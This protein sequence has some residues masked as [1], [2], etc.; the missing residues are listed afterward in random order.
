ML[1]GDDMLDSVQVNSLPCRIAAAIA[2]HVSR[3]SAESEGR[4]QL[5]GHRQGAGGVDVRELLNADDLETP[6]QG[7]PHSERVEET[8]IQARR[9]VATPTLRCCLQFAQ[10]ESVKSGR[11]E[12]KWVM[13]MNWK[14]IAP[15]VE[16]ARA[17]MQRSEHLLNGALLCP[18]SS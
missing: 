13:S 8:R 16:R 4:Q 3:I 14:W 17:T 11:L 5:P 1:L 9:I 18:R 12:L 7:R 6:A 10:S 2:I 15:T